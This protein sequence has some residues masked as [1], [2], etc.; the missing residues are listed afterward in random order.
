MAFNEE[1]FNNSLQELKNLNT[2]SKQASTVDMADNFWTQPLEYRQAI[3]LKGAKTEVRNKDRLLRAQLGDDMLEHEM[4]DGF[5]DSLSTATAPLF[6]MLSILNHTGAGAVEE[7]ATT[8]SGYEAFKRASSEFINA[9]PMLDEDDALAITGKTPTRATYSDALRK[10]EFKPFDNDRHNDYAIATTGFLLDILADPLT[11]MGGVGLTKAGGLGYT[12]ASKLARKLIPINALK[13]SAGMERGASL[14]TAFDNAT[15]IED[16]T[17]KGIDMLR[18]AP[19]VE[20]LRKEVGGRFSTKHTL[21]SKKRDLLAEARNAPKDSK[22]RKRLLSEA[23]STENFI[24]ELDTAERGFRAGAIETKHLALELAKGLSPEQASTLTYMLGQPEFH[25]NFDSVIKQLYQGSPEI[26]DHLIAKK[27]L[28]SDQ[29]QGIFKEGYKEG[30][31]D[32]GLFRSEY[33]PHMNPM[34]EMS[35]EAWVQFAKRL[36]IPEKDITHFTDDTLKMFDGKGTAENARKFQTLEERTLA[37]GQVTEFNPA[38]LSSRRGIEHAKTMATTNF[39]NAMMGDPSIKMIDRETLRALNKVTAGEEW[40]DGLLKVVGGDEA[41]S[42]RRDAAEMAALIKEKG[43]E[44][45]R[46]HRKT[47]VLGNV[48]LNELTGG[49]AS[50]KTRTWKDIKG[51]QKG[52]EIYHI[53]NKKHYVVSDIDEDGVVKITEIKKG[54]SKKGKPAEYDK[55]ETIDLGDNDK[56]DLHEAAPAMLLP[57]EFND[58]LVHAQ[59]IMSNEGDQLTNLMKTYDKAMGLWKGYALLSPGFHFRNMTS[60]TFQSFMAGVKD[61]ST[62]KDAYK[63]LHG[64][65]NVKIN[66]KIGGVDTPLTGSREIMSALRKQGVLTEQFFENEIP[67]E[68]QDVLFDATHVFGKKATGNREDFLK[69]LDDLDDSSEA[70]KLFNAKTIKYNKEEIVDGKKVMVESEMDRKDVLKAMLTDAPETSK[71]VKALKNA[72]GQDNFVLNANRRFGNAMESQ[73]RLAHWL[74]FA[75][76]SRASKSK[77][78]ISKALG[79]ENYMSAE[80]AAMDVKKWHFDYAELTDF[81][82]EKMKRLIPFYT[83]MRKNMPLQI[84]AI[85]RN[86]GRYGNATTKMFEAIESID[87]DLEELPIPDYFHELNMVRLPRELASVALTLNK[88]ADNLMSSIGFGREGAGEEGLQPLYLDPQLPFQDMNRFNYKDIVSSLTP[89][90]RVPIETTLTEKGHS[91]FLD[92]PIERFPGELSKTPLIPG[93]DI[94]LTGKQQSIVDAVLPP[95][96]KVSRMS[97]AF[98]EGKLATQ[99]FSQFPGI[100]T[101]T[102]DVGRVQRGKVYEKREKYRNLMKRMKQKRE[103]EMQSQQGE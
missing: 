13:P 55:G 21:K 27:K 9:L 32:T 97:K 50:N 84:E 73:V 29:M 59:K 4:Q 45:Y 5:F 90:I 63:I 82:R 80:D 99:F 91:V 22:E 18:K 31:W 102:V 30:L 89:L 15:W 75:D 39:F 92:R 12:G 57:K 98:G 56:F 85:A 72:F 62:H 28:F 76:T 38:I 47:K 3:A 51:V 7:L 26:A 41:M 35:K 1:E 10:M 54:K 8:G 14:A 94:R 70:G 87:E 40:S 60:A 77:T 88:K 71:I 42:V 96:G 48:T 34:G 100:A 37:G 67:K 101:R 95:L 17:A 52:E 86:P 24:N 93:T 83:W 65:E 11:Y 25:K 78:G 58:A 20:G 2:L 23:M 46:P 61:F 66:V 68:V 33:L 103:L 74:Y 44:I 49:V 81:E 43:Y 6:D 53:G 36:G 16:K 19:F 64:D 79:P 69:A